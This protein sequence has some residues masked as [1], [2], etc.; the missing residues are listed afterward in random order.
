MRK[1]VRY[2]S[3]QNNQMP[4]LKATRKPRVKPQERINQSKT[5]MHCANEIF[6]NFIAAVHIM[7]A[8]EQVLDG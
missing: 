6:E 3:M 7:S 2:E 5:N 8:T 1:E 4:R